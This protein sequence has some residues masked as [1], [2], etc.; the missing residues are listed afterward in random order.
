MITQFTGQYRFL[1]NFHPC[2]IIFDG[3]T[4]PSVE[5]AYQAAKTLDSEE[6]KTI[7]ACSTPGKAKRAGRKVNLRPDWNHVRLSIMT[8]LI[9]TKFSIPDLGRKLRATYPACLVE[10]NYWHD[11]FWGACLCF[12]CRNTKGQNHLGKILMT[13][14]DQHFGHTN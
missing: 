4:Y 2:N 5:H 9:A 12:K 11:D 10:G 8:S 13:E 6:R 3:E 1:S 7:R 14:R